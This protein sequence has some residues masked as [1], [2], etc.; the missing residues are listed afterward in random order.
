M[1]VE[2][3]I[4]ARKDIVTL[5]WEKKLGVNVEV[6]LLPFKYLGEISTS[7]RTIIASSYSKGQ[8]L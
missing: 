3:V 1:V 2:N 8:N 7:Y 4:S 5:F 6:R